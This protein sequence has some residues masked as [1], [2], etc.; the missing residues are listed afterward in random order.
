MKKAFTLL[1][2]MVAVSIVMILVSIVS[3]GYSNIVNTSI[4]ARVSDDVSAIQNAI[5]I[6]IMRYGN[7]NRY[8]YNIFT[9]YSDLKTALITANLI[10][11]EVFADLEKY[12]SSVQYIPQGN[13]Y[14]IIVTFQDNSTITFTP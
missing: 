13:T 6:Y 1:E 8:D 3:F 9:T 5:S 2:L 7:P 10:N 14:S 12:T 11:E 4:K